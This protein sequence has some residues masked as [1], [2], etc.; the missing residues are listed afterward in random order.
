MTEPKEPAPAA[1]GLPTKVRRASLRERLARN[2]PDARLWVGAA[3]LGLYLFAALSALV[4][5]RGA[6]QSVAI[7]GAWIYP[8]PVY[9][10]SWS[11]PFGVLPG[12]GV[13]LFR[14]LWVATPWDLSMVVG[15]LLIDTVIGVLLGAV[16]GAHEGGVADSVVTFVGDS[17][18]TIPT[19]F[20]VIIVFSG[21][22]T[23][24]PAS[25]GI[26]AFVAV[27]GV[28]LWPTMARAVRERARSVAQMKYVEAARASGATRR[29]VLFRHII[30]NS[31]GPA[32]AQIPLDVAPIFFVLS[33]FPWFFNCASTPPPPPFPGAPPAYYLIPVLPAFSPL[34]SP[35]FP[36]WG[37][38]L[39]IGA[40]EGIS[41][42]GQWNYW[43]MY[44]FPFL[45]I[46]GLALG[47][48]LLCDGLERWLR[49]YH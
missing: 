24:E 2:P 15:I 26:P 45:M 44:L 3:L 8:S 33:A 11:H 19:F 38:A 27:F 48:A 40:C 32:L 49:T 43:W 21:I 46:I 14:Y 12:V 28:V 39:A 13:D 30:P 9:P 10:P 47:I 20:F 23:V 31:L 4:V 34:P 1:A 6:V 36:E 37:F 16:A 18:A 22:A 5:F 25:A 35:N 42:P 29:H 7:T 41:Y 17:F